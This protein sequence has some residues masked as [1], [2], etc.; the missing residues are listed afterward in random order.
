MEVPIFEIK[1]E[2]DG[3]WMKQTTLD[4]LGPL[5]VLLRAHP[6]LREIRPT[7][8]HLDNKDFVHFHEEPEGIFADVRLRKGRLRMPVMSASEQAE[9][10]DR[11]DEALSSLDSRDK[12]R[13]R[14]ER[15]GARH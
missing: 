14:H 2:S 9:L 12:D 13:D 4:L 3:S 5:L 15:R 8:F 7:A 6:A 11:I 1:R 10:L